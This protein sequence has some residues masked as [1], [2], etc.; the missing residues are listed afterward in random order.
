MNYFQ[1]IVVL[2]ETIVRI[3]VTHVAMWIS[4]GGF[5]ERIDDKKIYNS[6]IIVDDNGEI[7]EVY[8]K[9]HLFDIDIPGGP[10]LKESTYVMPGKE[11]KTCDFS[12]I[13]L[14]MSICY[15]LRFP[16]LYQI[17][18]RK[19][20]DLILVPSAFT[21][22]TGKAHWHILLQC[23][24]IETQCYILAAAQ[25]GRH[26]EA[27]SS[28]G[29]SL[30]VDP[31]GKIVCDLENEEGIGYVDVDLDELKKVRQNMPLLEHR[32]NVPYKLL[33]K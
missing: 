6:H 21:E 25:T 3:F 20:S 15:D 17:L 12:D 9:I 14:G 1:N 19:E 33:E 11:I 5:P 4:Y 26:N 23:R 10:K 27:R 30:I 7:R 31:W 29:Y 18:R 16:E 22:H 13:R 24:A 32:L 28:F 8:R 2:H